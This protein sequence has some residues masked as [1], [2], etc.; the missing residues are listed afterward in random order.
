M[1]E[2]Y[3]QRI[4]SSRYG[5]APKYLP[6]GITD[7]TTKT[8]HIEIKRW[9]LYKHSLGQLLAYNAYDPKPY[10]EAHF[11][12]YYPDHKKAIARQILSKY[13]ILVVDLTKYRNIDKNG[14][15]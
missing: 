10:L 13:D 14:F 8:Q 12:G 9:P 1:H 5:G 3:Y 7:I 11:F 15:S 6:C 4:L 2:R